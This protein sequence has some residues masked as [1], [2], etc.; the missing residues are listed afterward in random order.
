MTLAEIMCEALE[1]A[2]E[3][4]YPLYQSVYGNEIADILTKA[5]MSTAPPSD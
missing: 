5:T 3:I 2:N 4:D 1:L